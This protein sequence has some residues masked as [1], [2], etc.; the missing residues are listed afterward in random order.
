MM[1]RNRLAFSKNCSSGASLGDARQG[2]APRDAARVPK[3]VTCAPWPFEYAE[4]FGFN[5]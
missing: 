3:D 5:C 2:G 1:T 4:Q